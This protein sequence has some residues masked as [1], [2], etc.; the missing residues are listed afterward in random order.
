MKIV[1]NECFG[2]FSLPSDFCELYGLDEYDDI[3][4]ADA[5]LVE[6]LESY[7][8]ATGENSYS[9]SFSELVIE[10]IPDNS[11]DW[12]VTEYDGSE[13]IVYVVDGKLHW[14]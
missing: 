3:D 14:V 7:F 11:T 1:I 10:E 12:H 4:R 6:F 9:E 8:A 5:R 13:S 2:G